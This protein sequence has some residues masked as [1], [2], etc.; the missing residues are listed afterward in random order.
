M[1]AGRDEAV[2][3]G[4]RAVS[5]ASVPGG[6]APGTALCAVDD[7][8]DGTSRVFTFRDDDGHRFEM[9]IHRNGEQVVAYANKCP[10]AGLPLDWTPG[11]F[12][13]FSGTVFHCASH[14]AQFRI[15]DGLCVA[16]PCPGRALTPV[17]MEVRDGVIRSV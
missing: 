10:H 16:G 11:R 5:L 9:F 14:G 7:I 3:S 1:V 15:E 2:L 6:P 12:L 13:D 8:A 17:K 4:P